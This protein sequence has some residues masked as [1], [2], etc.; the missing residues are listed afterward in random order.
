MGC[1]FR[2]VKGRLG[3]SFSDSSLRDKPVSEKGYSLTDPWGLLLG[4]G[5]SLKR[6]TGSARILKGFESL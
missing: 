2:R 5:K 6:G 4:N 3:A 1:D